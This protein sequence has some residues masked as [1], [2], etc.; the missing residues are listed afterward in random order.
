MLNKKPVVNEEVTLKRWTY[1]QANGM[2]LGA[3]TVGTVSTIE[4]ERVRIDF[5]VRVGADDPENRDIEDFIWLELGEFPAYIEGYHS[6][7]DE[8]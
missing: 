3:G 1:T 8:D 7:E 2:E 4:D 5:V 6:K